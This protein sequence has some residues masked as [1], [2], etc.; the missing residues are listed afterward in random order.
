MKHRSWVALAAM[1]AAASAVRPALAQGGSAEAEQLFKEGRAS[2]E[3]KDYA[4][5]C[6]RFTA[7]L[8]LERAVGTLISLAQCEEAS[9]HLAG[10]RQHWQEA[11]DLADATSDRL[12]RGPFARKKMTELDPRVPR[13]VV[14]LGTGAPKDTTIQR[15]DVPLG[16][17][18]FDVSF[19]VDPGPHVI[20][21]AAA[22]H[23]A[24]RFPLSVSEGEKVVV[25][26]V[27]GVEV[28]PPQPASPAVIQ[29]DSAASARPESPAA[30]DGWKRGAAYVAGAVGVVGL[31][32]GAYFGVSA[33]SK[34]SSAKTDCGSGCPENAPARTEKSDATTDATIA[35]IGL[36]VGVVAVAG[37][38]WLFV[39]A[40]SAKAQ[41]RLEL[42]PTWRPGGG[43]LVAEGAF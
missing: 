24:K 32:V 8:A 40:P 37:A 38:V 39:T 4:T 35:D 34:W 17:A 6:A 33:L 29:I 7:S 9:G 21:A 23:E 42:R 41:S 19:P 16:S 36:G 30:A 12:N 26:V 1:T 3:A 28:A 18:A 27:P 22:G 14:R 20:V 10:A 2:L 43:G 13:I 5:A 25:E 15:D 11:A 31:G